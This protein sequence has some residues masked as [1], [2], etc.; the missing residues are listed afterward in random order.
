[1]SNVGIAVLVLCV[2]WMCGPSPAQAEMYTALVHMEGLMDLEA[3]LLRSLNSYIT[4]EK[5]RYV[6]S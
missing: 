4:A 3:E 5:Q 6:L 2:A 1:M